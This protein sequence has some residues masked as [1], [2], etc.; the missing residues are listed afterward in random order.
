M[1]KCTPEA[2]KFFHDVLEE[3]KKRDQ[4]VNWGVTGFSVGVS[5]APNER[6]APIIFCY[7]KNRVEIWPAYLEYLSASPDDIAAIRK[8]L[9]QYGIFHESEKA[10]LVRISAQNI[11]RVRVAY[12]FWQSKIFNLT[13]PK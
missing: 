2:A 12:N 8:E 9:L 11:D 3:A 10:L 5:L 13:H 1:A 7:P 6:R 4:S